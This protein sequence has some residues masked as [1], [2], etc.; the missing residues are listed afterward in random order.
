MAGTPVL[1]GPDGRPIRRQELT[2]EWAAPRWAGTRRVWRRETVATGLTPQSLA[3]ILRRADEGDPYDFLTLAEEMEERDPHYFSVLGTRKRAVSG[4][5]PTVEAASGESRDVELADAIRD[6]VRRPGFVGMLEDAL[7]ALGKGFSAVEIL[8]DR[9]GPRWTP[10]SYVWRDPRF[11]R[12]DRDDGATLRLI[13]DADPI[14]GIPMPAGKFICHLPKLKSGLPVRGGLARVSAIAWMCKA[15]AVTDWVAY[16]ETYGQPWRIGKYERDATEE[17]IRRLLGA[18]A[19]LGTDAAAVIPA[20]MMIE[21]ISN[22]GGQ[23]GSG[24]GFYD[25]LCDFMDRQV[26]KAVLGQTMTSDSGS[27]RAQA[28]VHDRV[29]GDLRMSDARQ[30]A[31][32]INRDLVRPFIDLNFGPQESY[33]RLSLPV[34]DPARQRWLLEAIKEL[35]PLGLRVDQSVV[36]DRM[37][38][39]EPSSDS[40]LLEAPRQEQGPAA[41]RM[42]RALNRRTQT[43][44]L[45][46]LEAEA[47]EG[48]RRQLDPVVDPILALARRSDSYETFLAG[49]PELLEEMAAAELIQALAQATFRSRGLGDATDEPA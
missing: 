18:L 44:D 37:G 48:W 9:S 36:R 16:G 49:F 26:S 6:L 12:P 22:S 34:S 30:L 27:S 19:N 25:K 21:L 38:L 28:E 46:R 29:R 15:Y 1:Y 23:S 17:D 31:E 2:R 13:D 33:P 24:G 8:W 7:D 40:E 4:V 41:A 3:A 32:T 45:D 43:T 35:V 11:F 14:W 5:E 42:L 20:S 39:P 10:K 47:L